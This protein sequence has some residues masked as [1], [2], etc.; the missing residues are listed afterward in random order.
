MSQQVGPAI[1]HYGATTMEL[2]GDVDWDKNIF[3]AMQTGRLT[4]AQ[5]AW[6]WGYSD[7]YSWTVKGD[8]NGGTAAAFYGQWLCLTKTLCGD[9]ADCPN[10]LAA[11]G[12]F[13]WELEENGG[14][15]NR[16]S[17]VAGPR[18]TEFTDLRST[19]Q[20]YNVWDGMTGATN[21]GEAATQ[22]SVGAAGLDPLA[23]YAPTNKYKGLITYAPVKLLANNAVWSVKVAQPKYQAD[24]LY[25]WNFRVN[26]GDQVAL[27]Q[28]KYSVAVGD[29]AKY[30]TP[31]AYNP[32]VTNALNPHW[33]RTLTTVT[34]AAALGASMLTVGAALLSF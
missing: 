1:G 18:P 7:G 33:Q 20:S 11:D 32:L 23:W 27:Y 30:R 4:S 17:Y 26:D 5:A 19:T 14:V 31:G 24:G 21:G 12:M 3:N 15:P 13:C 2:L 16:F 22:A 10:S 29:S 28:N 9:D 34:G 8:R 25:K 6:L